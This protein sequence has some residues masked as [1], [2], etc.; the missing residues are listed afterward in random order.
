M[1]T[2]PL[3]IAFCIKTN[4]QNKLSLIHKLVMFTVNHITCFFCQHHTANHFE[5]LLSY[6]CFLLLAYF[7]RSITTGAII[8]FGQCLHKTTQLCVVYTPSHYGNSFLSIL[9]CCQAPKKAHFYQKW[10]CLV[11]YD[12]L[13]PLGL[14]QTIFIP[15]TF[16]FTMYLLFPLHTSCCRCH[17]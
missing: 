6:L 12:M 9:L 4:N 14:V 17:S 10:I 1:N 3:L 15:F 16:F 8:H 13:V 11:N 7:I 5:T 2:Y